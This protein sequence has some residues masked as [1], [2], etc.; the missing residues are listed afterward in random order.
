MNFS[1]NIVFVAALLSGTCFAQ[2]ESGNFQIKGKSHK[3]PAKA[4]LYRF[5]KGRVNLVDSSIV[6]KNTYSFSGTIG[7]PEM[8]YLS[9]DKVNKLP[10]FLEATTIETVSTGNHVDSLKISGSKSHDEFDAFAQKM[11]T[12]ENQIAEFMVRY[13][14]NADAEV[15]KELEKEYE[16]IDQA[17]NGFVGSFIRDNNQSFVSP[18]LISRYSMYSAEIQELRDLL[19]TLDESVSGSKYVPGIEQRIADLAKTEIGIQLP[20]FSQNN[21]DGKEVNIA[22]FRGQYVLID[23]WASWCGPC[24]K[25]NPNVVA[26]YEKYKDKNFTILG[27]SLDNNREKWLAAIEKDGLAW[28]HVSDLQGWS[29]AVADGFGVKSIPFSILIDPKG[30]IIG[31]NLRG[32]ELHT[33]LA[34]VLENK[35]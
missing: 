24:R 17:M 32:E 4:Y 27:V 25:E 23:F 22:D 33:F 21:A 7:M 34:E 19:A 20:D 11:K 28:S 5:D 3:G 16:G 2:S 35:P 14:A 13:R 8:A 6:K 26:A 18:Y 10:V 12:Y 31:K 1:T 15:A 30:K 29:N 9:F